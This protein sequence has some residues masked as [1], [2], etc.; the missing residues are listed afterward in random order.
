[1]EGGHQEENGDRAAKEIHLFWSILAYVAFV[2][3]INMNMFYIYFIYISYVAYCDDFLTSLFFWWCL[4]KHLVPYAL[5]VLCVCG[6][7]ALH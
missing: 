7:T 3:L 6:A 5:C 1:M 2:L 4:P